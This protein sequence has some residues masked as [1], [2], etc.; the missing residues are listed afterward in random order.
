MNN[1]TTIDVLEPIIT[2]A[3][4]EG[5]STTISITAYEANATYTETSTDT[6]VYIYLNETSPDLKAEMNRDIKL[7]YR[8]KP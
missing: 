1:K 8:R 2:P 6:S 7:S 3:I 4:S 5:R